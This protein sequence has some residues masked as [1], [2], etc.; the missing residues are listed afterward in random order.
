M[1][2]ALRSTKS[3]KRATMRVARFTGA[4]DPN[5]DRGA[6]VRS[7]SLPGRFARIAQSGCEVPRAHAILGAPASLPGAAR[8][9]RARVI[10]RA[11]PTLRLGNA[12][13]SYGAYAATPYPVLLNILRNTVQKSLTGS[14]TFR[15]T[16]RFYGYSSSA[17][18]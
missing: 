8:P 10:A 12:H 15:R 16:D 5:L 2:T 3:P 6:K 7:A 1:L 4:I 11:V 18:G 14:E 9:A 17:V 13:P